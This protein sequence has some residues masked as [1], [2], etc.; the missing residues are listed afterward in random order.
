[1][2]TPKDMIQS[3]KSKERAYL[4]KISV[5]KTEIMKIQKEPLEYIR[6]FLDEGEENLTFDEVKTILKQLEK[7]SLHLKA[8]LR[9]KAK[10]QMYY[11]R[12]FKEADK[13]AS[14]YT[15]ALE[16]IESENEEE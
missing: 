1:M 13:L 10:K 14:Q 4:S 9:W 8:S 12:F 2:S 3:F 16:V 11:T 15:M 6:L 7:E 5:K